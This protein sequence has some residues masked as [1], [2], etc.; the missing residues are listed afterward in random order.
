MNELERVFFV[1][2]L[3]PA[4]FS[5]MTVLQVSAGF[6]HC[7]AGA[8]SGELFC[9]GSNFSGCCGAPFPAV[10]FCYEPFNVPCIAARPMNLAL[11][12]AAYVLRPRRMKMHPFLFYFLPA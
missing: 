6:A 11:G 8:A 9:W 10:Q 3:L 5:P 12:K 1:S 7:A 4:A 2:S